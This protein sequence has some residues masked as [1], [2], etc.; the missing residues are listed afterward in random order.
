MEGCWGHS[1]WQLLW[2]PFKK[3]SVISLL[4]K[5]NS[6][7]MREWPF[8]IV[9]SIRKGRSITT[10]NRK[11]QRKHFS[12]MDIL[13][14]LSRRILCPILW[15]YEQYDQINLQNIFITLSLEYCYSLSYIYLP[16]Q[17]TSPYSKRKVDLCSVTKSLFTSTSFITSLFTKQSLP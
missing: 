2:C 4:R 15:I 12:T 10:S 14:K 8:I 6:Y 13:C 5:L 7:S 3:T 1:H 11:V 9:R 17:Y 16:T